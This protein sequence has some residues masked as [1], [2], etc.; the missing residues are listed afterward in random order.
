LKHAEFVK[1][2][3]DEHHPP[4]VAK[5]RQVGRHIHERA[6]GLDTLARGLYVSAAVIIYL[7]FDLLFRRPEPVVGLV[8][9][10]PGFLLLLRQGAARNFFS[11]CRD[12]G[13]ARG[14]Q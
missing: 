13:I 9:G 7:L 8:P 5:Q 2:H 6:N 3:A 10:L 1:P 14:Q 4:D 12:R 11:A